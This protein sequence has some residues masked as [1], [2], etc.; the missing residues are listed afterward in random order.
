MTKSSVAPPGVDL[1]GSWHIRT[2]SAADRDRINEAIGRAAGAGTDIIPMPAEKRQTRVSSSR[3]SSRQGKGG[4]VQVFLESGENL[5]VTQ[6]PHGIFISFDRSVVVE[7]R[8]G[9]NRMI[10]VGEI[11]AQRVSGWEGE[12]YVVETLDRKGMKLTENLYLSDD[13]E[14]LHRRIVLRKSDNNDV[15][16]KQSFSRSSNSSQEEGEELR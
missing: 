16:L 13:R 10:N 3:S 4:L 11:T 8:F 7:Y 9:E 12:Q 15:T 2:D 14:T 1:S 6:T 5:K